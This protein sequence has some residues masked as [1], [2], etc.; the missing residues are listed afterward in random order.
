M[1]GPLCHEFHGFVA[2]RDKVENSNDDE[3]NGIE[4]HFDPDNH[5]FVDN[6]DDSSCD[7]PDNNELGTYIYIYDNHLIAHEYLC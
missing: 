5:S 3:L 1:A 6:S 7:E 2:E 4:Y